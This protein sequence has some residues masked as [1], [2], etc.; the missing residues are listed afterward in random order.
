M[1]PAANESPDPE[2]GAGTVLVLALVA[3]AATGLL[4]VSLLAAAHSGRSAAQ[5]AADLAAIA[6]ADQVA[7]GIT[8]AGGSA[9][10]GLDDASVAGETPPTASAADGATLAAACAVGQA[11]AE[12]N[13]CHLTSC[14]DLGAGVVEVRTS[15]RTAA[16]VARAVAR[17]GPEEAR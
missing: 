5:T 9:S 2:R 11:T 13:G 16:G 8:G 10:A 12:A 4:T 17:A 15:R 7:R 6:V 3:A 1:T 14:D